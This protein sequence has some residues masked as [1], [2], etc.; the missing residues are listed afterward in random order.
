M[1]QHLSNQFQTKDLGK[2]RFFLGIEVAQS[3][4]GLVISQRKYAMDILEETCLLNAKPTDTPMNS[5]FKL[6]Y[7]QEEP[8]SDSRRYRRLVE[9]L[10]YLIVTSPYISFAVSVVSQFLNSPCQEHMD[11][12]I[13]ILRYIKCAPEKGLVYEDK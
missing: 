1:K 10:N 8:L 7:N 11:V 4:D 13:R 6:L 12:V 5:S 3:R 9:K 2:L